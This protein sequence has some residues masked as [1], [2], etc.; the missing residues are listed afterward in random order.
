MAPT[1][2]LAEVRRPQ[3]EPFRLVMANGAFYDIKHPDQC[4]VMP[5]SIVVGASRTDD[6]FIDWTV[7]LNPWNVLRI[8]KTTQPAV[9]HA[10]A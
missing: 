3:F 1:E 8:E 5:K 2:I 7:T 6:G 10:V 9:S 4:M